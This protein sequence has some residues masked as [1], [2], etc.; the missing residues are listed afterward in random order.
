[1]K[2]NLWYSKSMEQ[3]RWT[4]TDEKDTKW[5]EAGQRPVLRDAMED[6]AKTVEYMLQYEKKGDQR[7]GSAP[8]LHGEGRGF[9]SL[10]AH[11]NKCGKTSVKEGTHY[12]KRWIT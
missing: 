7:S 10:I 2:I 11:I 1:M 8:P 5:M 12:T 6:V 4:L 9:E 3:W